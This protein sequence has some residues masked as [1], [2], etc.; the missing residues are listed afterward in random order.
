MQLI[1]QGFLFL[2]ALVAP[3]GHL[4]ELA[5]EAHQLL[6]HLVRGA[7][8]VGQL[9]LEITVARLQ[10]LVPRLERVV[11]GAPLAVGVAALR[12]EQ[13]DL[14]RQVALALAVLGLQPVELGLQP[15]VQA[16]RVVELGFEVAPE[17]VPFVGRLK[18]SEHAR[19]I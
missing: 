18:R 8:L 1:S 5:D 3:L 19:M 2:P 9:L 14:A 15:V 13:A 12:R 6:A 11:A 4:P 16:L 17:R 7:P 10:R